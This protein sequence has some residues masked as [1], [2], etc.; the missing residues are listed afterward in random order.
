[1]MERMSRYFHVTSTANRASIEERGLDVTR[2]GAARGIAG[3]YSP[4]VDGCFLADGEEEA[5]WFVRLNNTGGEVD[6]WAVDNIDP[7]QL[8]GNGTGY[9]YLPGPIARQWLTLVRSGLPEVS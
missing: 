5:D 3:S 7:S 1:M 4:E 9:E 2:M 6:V 8:V